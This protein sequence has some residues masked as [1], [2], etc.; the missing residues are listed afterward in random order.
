MRRYMIKSVRN[1][2]HNLYTSATR[3]WKTM[4]SNLQIVKIKLF[5]I[6]ILTLSCFLEIWLKIRHKDNNRNPVIFQ[7]FTEELY[8]IS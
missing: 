1:Y 5:T 7:P 8:L 6:I 2:V 3:R 4:H